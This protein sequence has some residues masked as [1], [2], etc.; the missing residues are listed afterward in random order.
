M[1]DISVDQVGQAVGAIANH[2]IANGCTPAEAVDRARAAVRAEVPPSVWGAWCNADAQRHR[3]A[4]RRVANHLTATVAALTELDAMVSAVLADVEPIESTGTDDALMHAV[5]LL[6][7]AQS[8][9]TAVQRLPL[10]PS[11][12]NA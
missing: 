9:L 1:S 12:V 5:G 4:Q 3:R 7:D 6:R 2:H 11:G 10:L 8:S